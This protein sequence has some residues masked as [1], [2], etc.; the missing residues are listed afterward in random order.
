MLF[1]APVPTIGV[2]ALM[3]LAVVNY[4]NAFIILLRRKGSGVVLDNFMYSFID[5][6]T[7]NS[8]GDIL[9]FFI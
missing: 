9:L 3:V 1:N 2:D 6:G 7:G 5:F 8:R 4:E